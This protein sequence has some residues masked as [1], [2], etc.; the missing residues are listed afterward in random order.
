MYRGSAHRSRGRCGCPWSS[1]RCCG[2]GS[3]RVPEVHWTGMRWRAWALLAVMAGPL[4]AAPV[5]AAQGSGANVRITPARGYPGTRFK[6]AFT[7]PDAS[8]RVGASR[9]EYVVNVVGPSAEHGCVDA[10][11]WTPSPPKAHA[12]VRVSLNPK[13]LGGRWCVGTLHGTI[14]ELQSP[15]CPPLKLCPTFVVL[16]RTVG[17]FHFVVRRSAGSHDTTPPTFG[18]LRSAFACTPGAQRPGQRTPFT[19]KWAPATDNVTPARE[20]VYDVYMSKVRGGEDYAT[21]TWTTCARRHDFPDVRSR[22]PWHLL[23]RG[24]R[25][26]PRR[27]RGPQSCRASR[28]RSL[29][30]APPGRG[31]DGR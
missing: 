5:G 26:R 2:S 3:G 22:V 30:V 29:P 1:F 16:I 6:L 8:G 25:A 12:R 14:E 17:H 4:A 19:L 28:T 21:A 31:S 27:Q 24:A 18:G 9:R 20:I 11:S 13:T 15:V 10:G 23:L 7:A